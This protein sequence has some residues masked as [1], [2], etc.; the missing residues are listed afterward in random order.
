MLHNNFLKIWNPSIFQGNLNKRNYFEGWYFKLV[1]KDEKNVFAFIPGISVEKNKK[2]HCFIQFINVST[3][4]SKY[5]TFPMWDFSYREDRFEVKIANNIFSKDFIDININDDDFR[6]KGKVYFQ[7]TVPFPS[8]IHKPGI[9]G[10]Y[11][12]VPFME[13]YH[14]VVSINHSLKGSL[15]INDELYNL[16]SGKGY[17][18]KDWGKSFP[19]SWIWLQ[20][21]NFKGSN[22]SFMLSI[23]K[24]PWL[25]NHFVGFLG[26]LYIDGIVLNFATYTGAIIKDITIIKNKLFITIEDKNFKIN[27]CSIKEDGVELKAPSSGKM[28]RTIRESLNSKIHIQVF[29][30]HYKKIFDDIGTTVGLEISG[31]LK[32]FKK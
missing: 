21:N 6:I 29:N 11:S 12:F 15:I 26:F 19:S 24:I 28:E 2:G 14:G 16:D 18:E 25:K 7:D 3:G 30:K 1:S 4:E 9:M 31:D 10:W 20:C 5:F 27:L 23:A 32:D 8:K 13:C 17:I 22:S